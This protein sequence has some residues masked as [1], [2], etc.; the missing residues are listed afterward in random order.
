ML[1][2]FRAGS[3]PGVKVVEAVKHFCGS[4]ALEMSETCSSYLE[5]VDAVGLSCLTCLCNSWPPSG[6]PFIAISVHSYIDRIGG[7][8]VQFG[9]LRI[10]P[11][12]FADDVVLLA[13]SLTDLK[14]S[15]D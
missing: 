2:I 9:H 7:G 15:L 5:A 10:P 8:R 6:L 1:H 3:R 11:L 14:L 4:G 13:S 12:L